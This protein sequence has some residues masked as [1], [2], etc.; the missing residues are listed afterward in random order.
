MTCYAVSK[1]RTEEALA[2]L[3][4]ADFSPVFLRNATAYGVSPHLRIDLVVNNL[5]GW[6][7]IEQT[8]RI[9]SDGTP[10]RPL[11]HVEDIARAFAAILDAP[12]EAVHNQAF[13]VGV[14]SENHQVRDL[15]EMVRLAVARLQGHLRKPRQAPTHG[16]TLWRSDKIAAAVPAFQP[17]WTR[18]SGNL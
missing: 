14:N 2:K 16:A 17:Q 12:R 10:W 18:A 1:V 15:A 8:V 13:N 11:V 5:V 9:M 4:D 7:W 6:A 3:A